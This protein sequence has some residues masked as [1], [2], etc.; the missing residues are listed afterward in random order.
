MRWVRR[1][2][3]VTLLLG[4]AALILFATYRSDAVAGNGLLVFY[5]LI[6]LVWWAAW[7]V[8]AT[9]RRWRVRRHRSAVSLA[10]PS[11]TALQPPASPPSAPFTY[12]QPPSADM[13][14]NGARAGSR[15]AP[16][17]GDVL[18]LTP[19]QFE[20]LTVRLLTALGYQDVGRSGGAGDLGAD[21]V[22]RDRFGRTMVVQCKRFAPGSSVGSPVVQTFIGMLYG[23]HGADRGAIVTTVPFTEPAIQLARSQ[24]IALVDGEAL[25]LLLHLLDVPAQ[26][27]IMYAADR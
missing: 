19:G 26:V 15:R 6:G 18:S 5:V 7:W 12:A 17:L 21:V 10:S 20:D 3:I 1:H 22:A 23:Y 14:M 24:G 16:S 4:V 9:V 13:S 25:L 27:E 8:T 11:T 2:P